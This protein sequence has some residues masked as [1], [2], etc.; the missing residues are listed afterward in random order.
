MEKIKAQARDAFSGLT[1]A[2]SKHL[3]MHR[4][5][6]TI[7]K[8]KPKIRIIHIVAPEIIKTDVENFRDLVQRL[9]GKS[10]ESNGRTKK[11]RRALPSKGMI[12]N[13]KLWTNVQPDQAH[14]GIQFLQGTPRM[15][16]G[17]EYL[18]KG[19]G[20]SHGVFGGFGDM[21]INLVQD[22]SE[23]PVLSFK[24]SQSEI[25]NMLGEMQFC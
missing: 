18:Y 13:R 3:A 11:E 15:K 1:S 12:S 16:R 14:Q 7:S 2:N 25:N 6:H 5:S 21:D 10:A 24:S 4:D 20:T 19:E 17:I 8:L 23:F 9:T 22:L